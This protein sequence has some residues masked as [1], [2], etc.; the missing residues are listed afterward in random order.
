[1]HLD[2]L[3]HQALP[4]QGAA[5]ALG[6]ALLWALLLRLA[7]RRDLAALGA[8][9]GLA[10]GWVLTLGLPTASPRQLPERL[11][12]LALAGLLAG[13]VLAQ[14]GR[15][16]AR[17]TGI[18]AALLVLAA[19]WWLAGAPL[20]PADLRRGALALLALSLLA[21]GV[22][23][24]L[25]SPGRAAAALALL[26]AGFW[27]AA[28]AGPWLVLAAAALAAALGGLAG[29]PAWGTAAALPVA[30]G[31]A[32]LA[33][34]PVLARGAAADWTAAAAGLAALWLGPALAARIGGRFGLPL[35]WG[36]AGGLPLLF[37]WLL[38]RGS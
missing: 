38:V 21:A 36:L 29:G 28:P 22:L 8:G 9:A 5:A 34:G 6:T 7:G 31:L 15:G 26:L 32:G 17:L 11:P 37:T 33:A 13:L 4:W 35:G 18:G 25:R 23:L 2:S 24:E 27:L 30:L 14:W 16:R 12:L 20:V 3:W 1:M 10:L 19:G